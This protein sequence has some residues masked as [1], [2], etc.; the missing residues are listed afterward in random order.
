MS[1]FANDRLEQERDALLPMHRR[2]LV[3]N[4]ELRVPADIGENDDQFLFTR[5]HLPCQVCTSA[6]LP[7][8]AH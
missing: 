5:L 1:T 6:R 3:L 2:K 4:H 7:S 8:A